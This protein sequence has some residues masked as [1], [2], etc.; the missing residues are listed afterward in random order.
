M[1]KEVS[2]YSWLYEEILVRSESI[3]D[4]MAISLRVD[5][6]FFF[7]RNTNSVSFATY[8]NNSLLFVDAFLK[9]DRF[10]GNGTKA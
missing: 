5:A 4:E 7:S 10:I 3:D 8:S 9:S 2:A 6:M 1:Q